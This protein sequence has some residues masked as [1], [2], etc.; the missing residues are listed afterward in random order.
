VFS[1][2][3]PWMGTQQRT[4]QNPRH[5]QHVERLG[6]VVEALQ[7]QQERK[8]AATYEAV[9]MNPAALTQRVESEH[10]TNTAIQAG[11]AIPV[12]RADAHQA[13]ISN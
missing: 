3:A 4:P 5:A 9:R 10:L 12:V 13:G 8:I 7:E 6:P 11:E 1:T 2:V